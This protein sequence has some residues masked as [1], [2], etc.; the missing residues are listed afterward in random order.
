MALEMLLDWCGWMGV[1]AQR[2]LLILGIPD[3]CEEEE[4]QEAVH[5]ALWALGRFR[6]LAGVSV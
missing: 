3:D 1:N 2:S 5:A 6:V 4:F